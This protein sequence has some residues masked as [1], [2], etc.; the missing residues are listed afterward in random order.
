ML[1]ESYDQTNFEYLLK[2]LRY[3]CISIDIPLAT[4]Y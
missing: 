1:L 3:H 2:V 4:L